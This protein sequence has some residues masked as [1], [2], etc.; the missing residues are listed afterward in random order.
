MKLT[1]RALHGGAKAVQETTGLASAGLVVSVTLLLCAVFLVVDVLWSVAMLLLWLFLARLLVDWAFGD[2]TLLDLDLPRCARWR[3]VMSPATLELVKQA[4][5]LIDKPEAWVK[6]A[7]AVNRAGLVVAPQS[8]EACKWCL[9]G[10]I[11]AQWC[12]EVGARVAARSLR[13]A[14]IWMF[15]LR[16]LLGSTTSESGTTEYRAPTKRCFRCSTLHR[17]RRSKLK[18]G[19]T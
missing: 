13:L 17:E 3:C 9:T 6:G 5:K 7:D 8:R 4:R 10:A 16:R 1:K 15:G 19:A 14:A 2:G 12:P 18:G 11:E